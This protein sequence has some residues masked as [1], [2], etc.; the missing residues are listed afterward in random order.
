MSSEIF[1]KK[2]NIWNAY[3]NA[4][5]FIEVKTWSDVLFLQEHI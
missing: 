2:Q 3:E 1:F 4:K 5:K